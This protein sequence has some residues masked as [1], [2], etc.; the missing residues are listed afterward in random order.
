MKNHIR[1]E[2]A[3]EKNMKKKRNILLIM[4][5]IIVISRMEERV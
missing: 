2:I 1:V 3:V 4:E 5:I